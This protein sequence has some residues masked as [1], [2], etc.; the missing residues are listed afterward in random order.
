[1]DDKIPTWLAVTI[2]AGIIWAVFKFEWPHEASTTAAAKGTAPKATATNIVVS[3]PLNAADNAIA[4][5]AVAAFK[6]QCVSLIRNWGDVRSAELSIQPAWPYQEEDRGWKRQVIIE[7]QIP[8]NTKFIPDSFRAHGQHCRYMFG[9]DSSPGMY[10]QKR[11]CARLCDM[12]VT[13]DGSNFFISIPSL[14]GMN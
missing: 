6:T 4:Q 11:S 2:I 5:K 12:Q 7:I 14:T 8:E 3:R 13:T 1:M 9:G 10:T